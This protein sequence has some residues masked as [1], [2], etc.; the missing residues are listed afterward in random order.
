MYTYLY[1]PSMSVRD[2]RF[3]PARLREDA[4]QEAWVAYLEGH[5]PRRQV[6]RFV[7]RH[8]RWERRQKPGSQLLP[9][10]RLQT[11]PGACRHGWVSPVRGRRGQIDLAGLGSDL[12]RSAE[13]QT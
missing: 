9:Q 11:G 6:Q 3:V 12:H 8:R 1:P 13:E 5:N 10:E 7:Q 4:I 2:F